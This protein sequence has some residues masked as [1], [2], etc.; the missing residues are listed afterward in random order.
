VSYPGTKVPASLVPKG[1]DGETKLPFAQGCKC[2]KDQSLQMG[3]ASDI[4]KAPASRVYTR[5]Y[6]KIGREPDDKDL[7][8][9]ALGNPLRL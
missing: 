6:K 2:I 8:T 9:E 7:V 3:Q 4:G 5:D 1:K